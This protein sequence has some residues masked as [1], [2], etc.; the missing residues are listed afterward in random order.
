[1]LDTR[2]NAAGTGVRR[3]RCCDRCA[4]RFTTYETVAGAPPADLDQRA[5]MLAAQLRDLA[6]TLEAWARGH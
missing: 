1:V 4:H 2:G 3:R 5:H 6:E